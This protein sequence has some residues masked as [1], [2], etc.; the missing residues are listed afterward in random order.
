MK[1]ITIM[2]AIAAA[3]IGAV[4]LTVAGSSVAS[5]SGRDDSKSS[6]RSWDDDGRQY[7]QHRKASLPVPNAEVVRRAGIVQV[8]EI[9]R[10]DGR[11]EVEGYDA[12]GREIKLYM[13]RNGK[14]V[15]SIRRDDRGDD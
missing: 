8:K 7:S 2:A 3:A 9:E 14:N 12:Q 1:R 10:D 5:A 11:L 15:I 13:D 4:S 6:S